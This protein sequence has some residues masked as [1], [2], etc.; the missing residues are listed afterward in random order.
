MKY[1]IIIIYII[2][3][4]DVVYVKYTIII[5]IY[6]IYYI[7]MLFILLLLLFILLYIVSVFRGLYIVS[8][9]FFQMS[10]KFGYSANYLKWNVAKYKS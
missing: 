10:K 8:N 9:T 4:S 6:I 7:V 5:I 3:Y 1:T 2:I